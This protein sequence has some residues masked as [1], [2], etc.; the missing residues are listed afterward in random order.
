MVPRSPSAPSTAR[1]R[2]VTLLAHVPD[3]VLAALST[4]CAWR[5]FRPDQRIVSRDA[6]DSDVYLI[7]SGAVRVT[8]FSAAGRQL[9]FRDLCDGEWFGDLAAIDR[10]VRSADVV[11]LSETLVASLRRD[12]FLRLIAENL[13]AA[14]AQMKHLVG[15]VRALTDRLFDLSTLG[16][17]H[18]VQA[19][20][21]RL[22]N[23]AGVVDNAARIE[24]APTHAE[25]ASQVSTNREQV[26]RELSRLAKQGLVERKGN[27]LVVR[28][29]SR[30]ER[31][32]T[33]VRLAT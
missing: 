2:A 27:A 16:V 29:V 28:D 20:L 11:A 17:Q 4:R 9:I 6:K 14:D 5:R 33:Q 12:D 8:A 25:M 3:D 23:D 32:V 19:E 7:V 26:T 31:I 1:L 22:A 10:R 30:L 18:R 13:S 15:W 21:L 24:P